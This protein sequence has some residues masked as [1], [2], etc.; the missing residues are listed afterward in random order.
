VDT[1][2]EILVAR[3]APGADAVYAPGRSGPF[4][5]DV[6]DLASNESA[7]GPSPLARKAARQALHTLHRYPEAHPATLIDRLATV[8]R[9]PPHQ[10][11]PGAGEDHLI[12]LLVWAYAGPLDAVLVPWP[13]FPGYVQAIRGAGARPVFVPLASDGRLDPD[14]YGKALADPAV[15]LVV[16]CSP[17][18]PTGGATSLAV[19]DSICRAAE[20]RGLLTVVDEAYGEF[21]P[22]AVSTLPWVAAGRP[23]VVLRTFS[24]AYGLAGL[25][26]GW[27]AGPSR[28]V[29]LLARLREPFAVNR[30]AIA[31]AEAALADTA[32]LAKVVRAV[33]RGRMAFQ[34]EAA[35]R[36]LFT[37]PSDAN[38][39][40]LKLPGT[41]PDAGRRAEALRARGVAVRPGDAFGLPGFLRVTVGRPRD[42]ARFWAAWTATEDS[43]VDSATIC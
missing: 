34:A 37:Y 18:N 39:V 11:L 28:V 29:S 7:F 41:A 27:L 43:A 40:A 2:S 15:R 33:S 9:L 5:T 10:I 42:M 17:H 25:R 35:R 12:R 24:K 26:I 23:V 8:H 13:G 30:V 32:H 22:P 19:L 14:R 4:R 21:C 16:L 38:F 3:R 31:A 6:A 36:R 20:A 1:K